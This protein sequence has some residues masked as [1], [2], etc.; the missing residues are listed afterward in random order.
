MLALIPAFEH[1]SDS[2]SQ[3]GY[4]G[5]ISMR[6]WLWKKRGEIISYDLVIK[7]MKIN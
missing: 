1:F 3:C 4:I 7:T 6:N 5:E 2:D